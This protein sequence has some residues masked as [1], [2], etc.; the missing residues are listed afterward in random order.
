[1]SYFYDFF[2]KSSKENE[3][4]RA[5]E[6]LVYDKLQKG[7][8]SK[9]SAKEIEW[10]SMQDSIQSS[11]LVSG[12]FYTFEYADDLKGKK[13]QDIA[14]MCLCISDEGDTVLGFN[15]NLILNSARAKILDELYS[16][17]KEFFDVELKQSLLNKQPVVSKKLYYLFKDKEARQ[18]FIK[19]VADTYKIPEKSF[20]YRKYFKK[21]MKRV[22]MIDYWLWKWIPFLNFEEGIR[23]DSLKKIQIEGAV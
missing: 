22:S 6:Y 10:Y 18:S 2:A 8:H 11:Q 3:T 21:K 15:F 20:A 1:M 12:M 5:Y 4:N 17:D 14:P 19:M 16:Y 9:A 7:D 13:F 23:G